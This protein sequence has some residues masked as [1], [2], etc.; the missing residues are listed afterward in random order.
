[1]LSPQLT[2]GAAKHDFSRVVTR[3]H[4]V[5]LR[6]THE[7]FRDVPWNGPDSAIDP[8]DPRFRFRPDEPLGATAWYRA[9][10]PD[11]QSRLG[12][13]FICQTMRFGIALESTLSVGL[14]GLI[15]NLP[16][17]SP[18]FHYAL[19]EII[20]ESK[21]S[22]MFQTFIDKSGCTPAPLSALDRWI[23]RRIERLAPVYPEQFF[24]WVLAGEIFVDA[25]NRLR[26]EHRATLHPLI[27]RMM[28]IHVT[29]E[30]RH[31][32][33]AEAYLREHLPRLGALGRAQIR[34]V[35]TFIMRGS[36]KVMLEPSPAIVQRFAI[37]RAV[38]R[39]A[40]GPG[41]PHRAHK[42]EIEAAVHAVLS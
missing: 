30:A 5:S 22:Q 38:L 14:L 1:M 40:F 4:D 37:P 33:F 8:R 13:E 21:H 36:S 28:Q 27:E 41:T 11:E 39:E 32:R 6:K 2:N 18:M 26:L 9:L 19:T 24:V 16:A 12:L 15:R 35:A 25:D 23:S 29:E 42:A 34:A 7:P 17:R 10:P 3:L 31:M 20:E